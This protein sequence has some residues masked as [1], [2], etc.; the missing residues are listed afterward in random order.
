[1]TVLSETDDV[2]DP[3]VEVMKSLLDGH[4]IL[5]RQLAEQGH[6]PAID[7]PISVSR[8]SDDLIPP[9]LT[10]LACKATKQLSVYEDAR[11]MVE[12]GMYKTGANAGLDDAI[13]SRTRLISFL[14]QS[15]KEH[16]RLEATLQQLNE[17][18]AK[19]PSHV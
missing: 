7:V 10:R 4:I 1:M 2:D 5:S 12:S 9:Q 3:I 15:S 19:V 18:F 8:Q 13:A 14:Q 6:F 11:I 16:S 17:I